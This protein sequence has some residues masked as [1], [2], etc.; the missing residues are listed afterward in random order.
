MTTARRRYS[1]QRTG[2]NCEAVFWYGGVVENSVENFSKNV[3]LKVTFNF[4]GGKKGWR[5]FTD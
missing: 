1:S 5:L 2:S 4:Y 3:I